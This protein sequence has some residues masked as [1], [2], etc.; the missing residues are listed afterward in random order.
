MKESNRVLLDKW[1]TIKQ[2]IEQSE[3][4]LGIKPREIFWT[5]I[6]QNIGD[7]E[8]GKG[9][10]FSRPVIIVRQL[11]HDLFIGV[12]IT[13]TLKENDYFQMFE[14]KTKRGI[15]TNSAMLLQIRTFSKKRL[16]SK[17]GKMGVEDFQKLQ[18]KLVKLI[19]PT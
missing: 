16:T 10:A 7:E 1:N 18:R 8:Y 2:S 11:T 3:R 5:K 13:T 6:G 19:V 17:L 4:Q 9:E 15:S 14:F 12:P